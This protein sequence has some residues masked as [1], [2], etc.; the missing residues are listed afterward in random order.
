[1]V[2]SI[3]DDGCGSVPSDAASTGAGGVSDD[4]GKGK[5]DGDS[6]GDAAAGPTAPCLWLE[7]LA[8]CSKGQVWKVGP[9][10]GTLGRASDN[11]V[12]LAD[13]EMSRRHS[14]V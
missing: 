11:N 5:S 9:E 12:S 1:M 4:G 13:K 2:T 10:G 7:A 8:G 6:M 3:S 14:K